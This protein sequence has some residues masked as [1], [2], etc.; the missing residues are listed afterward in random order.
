MPR[1]RGRSLRIAMGAMRSSSIAAAGYDRDCR[2]LR[3]RYIGGGTYDYREVAASVFDAL[4]E[5]PS[6]G[7]F[8]NWQIKPHYR[9]TRLI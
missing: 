7:Q 6:K 5:A 3:V 9:Y 4:L 2:T 1:E 8:V